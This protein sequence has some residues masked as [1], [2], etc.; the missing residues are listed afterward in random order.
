[1]E[2]HF[3]LEPREDL[4]RRAVLHAG[5]RWDER[6]N[7]WTLRRSAFRSRLFSRFSRSLAW[8]CRV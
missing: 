1:M 5:G 3:R 8:A 6:S 4:L 7:T 2:V